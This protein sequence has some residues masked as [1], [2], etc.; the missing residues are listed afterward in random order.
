LNNKALIE[1]KERL[2]DKN[3]EKRLKRKEWEEDRDFERESLKR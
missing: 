1:E 2:F 3:Y